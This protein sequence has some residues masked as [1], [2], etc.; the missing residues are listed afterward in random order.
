M[1]LDG[2]TY[3]RDQ[4]NGSD[5]LL[6]FL[7]RVDKPDAPPPPAA[8]EADQSS[9]EPAGGEDEDT[10]PAETDTAP[11]AETEQTSSGAVHITDFETVAYCKKS[12]A[13][14]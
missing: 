13:L 8:L 4:L 14:A 6:L 1:F 7:L 11:A 12:P 2:G 3:W 10:A 5:T 9:S